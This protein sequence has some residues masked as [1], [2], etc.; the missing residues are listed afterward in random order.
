MVVVLIVLDWMFVL[1]NIVILI[2]FFVGVFCRDN[3][4]KEKMR[5]LLERVI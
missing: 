5:K 1:I 3:W 4:E 2:M